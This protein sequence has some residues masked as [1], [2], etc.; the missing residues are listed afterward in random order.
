MLLFLILSRINH[1][2]IANTPRLNPAVDFQWKKIT[3][4]PLLNSLKQFLVPHLKPTQICGEYTAG[5]GY[6]HG[7]QW[8]KAIRKHKLGISQPCA[9]LCLSVELHSSSQSPF[10]EKMAQARPGPAHSSA[11]LTPTALLCSYFSAEQIATGRG[12]CITQS[13]T[14]T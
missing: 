14:A 11:S 10:L 1:S 13:S 4:E 3:S 6:A 12:A 8:R 5:V 9:E 2:S 7:K